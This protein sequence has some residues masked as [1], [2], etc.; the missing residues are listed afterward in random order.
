MKMMTRVNLAV[1]PTFLLNNF[2]LLVLE[3]VAAMIILGFAASAIAQQ[4]PYRLDDLFSRENVSDAEF[5][6]DGQILVFVRTRPKNTLP[7]AALSPLSLAPGH[8]IWIHEG[9][10]Q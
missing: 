7:A 3:G 4:R 5:S 2:R 6:P 9:P 8:D 10:G 1:M